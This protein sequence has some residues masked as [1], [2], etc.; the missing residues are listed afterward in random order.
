MTVH[1][2]TTFR[3]TGEVLAS[4]LELDSFDDFCNGYESLAG[5]CTQLTEGSVIARTTDRM[6]VH[7]PGTGKR[8]PKTILY[9]PET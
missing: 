2:I 1:Q 4:A 3:D 8:R 5:A 6:L 9:L 7:I